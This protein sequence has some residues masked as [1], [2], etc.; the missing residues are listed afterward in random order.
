MAEGG[1]DKW[2]DFN[3]RKGLGNPERVADSATKNPERKAA[4]EPVA[5]HPIAKAHHQKDEAWMKATKAERNKTFEPVQ[6]D[7]EDEK[8]VRAALLEGIRSL[9]KEK[10]NRVSTLADFLSEEFH[11]EYAA[12]VANTGSNSN[13]TSEKLS[14]DAV[15]SVAFGEANSVLETDDAQEEVNGAVAAHEAD[16]KPTRKFILRRLTFAALAAV[17]LAGALKMSETLIGPHLSH[18]SV[19]GP[20][21]AGSGEASAATP[22]HSVQTEETG[23]PVAQP[24]ASETI[25]VVAKASEAEQGYRNAATIEAGEGAQNALADLLRTANPEWRD[26]LLGRFGINYAED[27]AEGSAAKLVVDLGFLSEAGEEARRRQES[28]Q[29]VTSEQEESARSSADPVVSGWLNLDEGGRLTLL[30]MQGQPIRLFDGTGPDGRY[31]HF[32]TRE[33]RGRPVY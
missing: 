10:V 31:F 20:A 17:G 13:D 4:E 2:F 8:A 32:R 3:F 25:E 22:T 5:P 29:P 14:R 1:K 28:H 19:S 6:I 23:V 30:P 24:T 12:M 33:V 11:A 16:T 18:A 21:S 26:A 15:A 9:S 7:Q 27:G